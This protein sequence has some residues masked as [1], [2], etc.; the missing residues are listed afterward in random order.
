M[1]ELWQ[2][3][4]SQNREMSKRWSTSPAYSSALERKFKSMYSA[5]FRLESLYTTQ[6]K[7]LSQLVVF[8]QERLPN[9]AKIDLWTGGIFGGP[10][11]LHPL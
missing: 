1:A 4:H 7:E 5:F 2:A 9:M 8:G 6:S 3:K 11:T 10:C